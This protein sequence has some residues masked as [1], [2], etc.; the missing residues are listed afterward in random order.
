M[1][2]LPGVGGGYIPTQSLPSL[3]SHLPLEWDAYSIDMYLFSYQFWIYNFQTNSAKVCIRSIILS[4]QKAKYSMTMS[5]CELVPVSTASDL[6]SS[7]SLT[8][9]N[10]CTPLGWTHCAFLA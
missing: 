5:S 9:R 1:Q 8:S 2:N 3:V 4:P 10:G 7:P 6:R